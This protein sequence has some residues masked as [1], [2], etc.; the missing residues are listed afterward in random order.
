MTIAVL[1]KKA[2]YRSHKRMPIFWCKKERLHAQ[3]KQEEGDSLPFGI[4]GGDVEFMLAQFIPC[5]GERRL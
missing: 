4:V 3:S 2:T 1:L 5:G